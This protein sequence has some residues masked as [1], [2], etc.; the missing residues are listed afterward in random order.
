MAVDIVFTKP[1][2]VTEARLGRPLRDHLEQRYV[3]DGLTAR[4]L[5][6]EL[7]VSDGTILRWLARLGIETRFPGQR[8]R[9]AA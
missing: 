4:Q 7:G 8:G 9:E 2:R 5:G 6:A 1:M 3:R